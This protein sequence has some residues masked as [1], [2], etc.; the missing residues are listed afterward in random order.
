MF[1][2]GHFTQRQS[3]EKCCWHLARTSRE[4]PV[5]FGDCPFK[6]HFLRQINRLRVQFA[7][8]WL[9]TK[10]SLTVSLASWSLDRQ[11][12]PQQ[13]VTE[14]SFKSSRKLE[15]ERRAEGSTFAEMRSF[16]MWKQLRREEMGYKRHMCDLKKKPCAEMHC[17]SQRTHERGGKWGVEL[18]T[19]VL[20]LSLDLHNSELKVGLFV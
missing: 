5:N 18:C 7:K 17:L 1:S 9:F 8:G 15:Q 2:M 14:R 10:Y 20:Q 16:S 6:G 13:I 11:R 4:G 12:S 19:G 3:P